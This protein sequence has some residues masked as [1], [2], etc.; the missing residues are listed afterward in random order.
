MQSIAKTLFDPDGFCLLQ[1]L[2]GPLG[3]IDWTG[4]SSVTHACKNDNTALSLRTEHGS[5][6]SFT[7]VSLFSTLQFK[8]YSAYFAV[9]WYKLSDDVALEETYVGPASGKH[10]DSVSV[11]QG[12]LKSC[13]TI[14][15]CRDCLHPHVS[16]SLAPFH[17][18]IF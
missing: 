6:G 7:G 8:N 3:K 14:S 11:S 12:R 15:H 16:F 5:F 10:S 2:K 4:P 18:L 1:Q 9:L 13:L 17:V